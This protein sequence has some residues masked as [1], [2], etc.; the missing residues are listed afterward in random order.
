MLACI[1]TS[2]TW[3][4]G[5]QSQTNEACGIMATF[6][7]PFCSH[8]SFCLSTTT[9][10]TTKES[11]A[12]LNAQSVVT[13]L[14]RL[15]LLLVLQVMSFLSLYTLTYENK[16]RRRR[17]V[18][19]SKQTLSACKWMACQKVFFCQNSL[20]LSLHHLHFFWS[21][22]MDKW[23]LCSCSSMSNVLLQ[24]R[25]LSRVGGSRNANNNANCGRTIK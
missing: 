4:A 12:S 15:L 1:S 18:A 21:L 17:Y 11:F 24:P 14:Q 19:N 6:C 23:H 2:P 5:G 25:N 8:N 16:H 10:A 22:I 13:Q 3:L 7:F 9:T 20:S